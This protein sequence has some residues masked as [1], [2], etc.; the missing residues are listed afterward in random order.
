M[1]KHSI[2]SCLVLLVALTLSNGCSSN[3]TMKNA[4]KSTKGAWATYANP[5]ANI[6]YE[7]SGSLGPEQMALATRMM[8]I[9]MQ[10]G[11]LERV[12]I[13]ADK[14]PTNEWLAQFFARF[15]WVS[16]FA[17]VKADGQIIGQEPSIPM[18]P[19]D[20]LPLLDEDGKQGMRDLRGYVQDTPLGAEVFLATPLYDASTFLGVVVAHF[21]MRALLSYSTNPEELV[22]LSPDA[23]LWPG[24][25]DIASTPLANV[26]WNDVVKGSSS[27]TLSNATGSFHWVLRYFGNQPL[28]FAV[29]ATGKF[30]EKSEQ[31]SALE[32]AKTYGAPLSSGMVRPFDTSTEVQQGSTE[33]LLL[34]DAQTPSPFGPRTVEEKPLN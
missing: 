32:G 2:K 11:Q 21:D 9:D 27:G 1:L 22:I 31:L 15:P 26:K 6:D 12:M 29:P 14:P 5:K 19:L 8:G 30:P 20:Y 34:Q 28:I 4:W 24:K 3:Q 25:F 7:D 17:G 23:V 10:L 13:N 33:S 16:G 18:K